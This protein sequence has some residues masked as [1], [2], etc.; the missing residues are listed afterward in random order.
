MLFSIIVPIYKVEKYL[1]KCIDSILGQSF[2]DFEL[3]LVDDGSPDKCPSI[4]D[5][6]AKKDNRIKVIH[7]DNGGLSDARNAGIEIARGTYIIF[8]DSDD[9]WDD[10]GALIKISRIIA[11]KNPDMVTWRFK[12]YIEEKN[13]I[14]VVG[15]DIKPNKQNDFAEL[16]KTRNFTVSACCKAMKRSLFDKFGLKFQKG[17]YSEDIEWCVRVLSVT[18]TIIPSNLHFYVYR[19]RLGSITHSIGRKNI[20][21][22]KAHILSI[23]TRTQEE[24]NN[25]ERMDRLLAEEFCNF[26]VTLTA[27]ENYKEECNWIKQKKYLLK[28]TSSKKSKILRLL[29]N[30][31]GVRLTIK[32]IKS[33][34]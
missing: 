5:E 21:D 19:Q 11:E 10:E 9:Y 17:V 31:L 13:Q 33:A 27:Y 20:E 18:E 24:C 6:Y 29:I 30:L 22:V 34:R 23:E 2:L 15:K 26:I 8:M 32:L 12:K 7:K 14:S 1:N 16:I 25:R 3:I 4:C 28:R